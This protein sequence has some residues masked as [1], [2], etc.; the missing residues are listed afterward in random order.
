M[1]LLDLTERSKRHPGFTTTA[2]TLPYAFRVP[3][4]V[5]NQLNFRYLKSWKQTYAS[6]FDA[7]LEFTDLKVSKVY[8]DFLFTPW[9]FYNINLSSYL[10]YD[11]IPRLEHSNSSLEI[12][13]STFESN[14]KP[15]II[16]DN[17]IN[18]NIQSAENL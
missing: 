11:N 2:W 1:S 13:Q 9:Y 14:N 17:I 3:S 10:K 4:N 15:V 5:A 7:K 8:S 12:F 6:L 16:N 18:T